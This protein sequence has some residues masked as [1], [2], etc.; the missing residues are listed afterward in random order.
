MASALRSLTLLATSRYHAQVLATEA[1]VPTVAVSM[2][3]RLVNL[4][5]E[6]RC[7]P[8]LLL[9]VDEPDLAP[10]LLVALD[11][12]CENASAIREGLAASL[13]NAKTRLDDMGRWLA[14]ELGV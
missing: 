13:Q 1:L 14:C 3:E 2:D 11:Y 9:S 7:D 5:A 4:A 6:L 8:R 10:R 12:A